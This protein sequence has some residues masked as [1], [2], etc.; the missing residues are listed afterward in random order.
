MDNLSDELKKL[1]EESEIFVFTSESENFPVVLLEAMLSG[2]AIITTNDNGCAEVV[3]DSAILVDSKNS[4]AIKESLYKLMS[5]RKLINNLQIKARKRVE[6]KF[7]WSHT[8]QKH[9]DVYS[10][11]ISS[12]PFK[13]PEIYA[14]QN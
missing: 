12:N 8:T 7:S 11:I 10:R 3:G 4:N 6:D 9:I 13:Y 1:Y 2:M 5:D 14:G